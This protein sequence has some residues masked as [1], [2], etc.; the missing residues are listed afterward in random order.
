M[1]SN[2]FGSWAMDS[3]TDVS[4]L[5]LAG[6]DVRR[7]RVPSAAYVTSSGCIAQQRAPSLFSHC[8]PLACSARLLATTIVFGA[9]VPREASC[10]P[11]L[12]TELPVWTKGGAD[13]LFMS[14]A[15]W[16]G[17]WEAVRTRRASLRS[18]I[19]ISMRLMLGRTRRNKTF[20]FF[21][22][23][24]NGGKKCFR[25]LWIIMVEG[26]LEMLWI[27]P[28]QR[29]SPS[30]VWLC[31]LTQHCSVSSLM[32][33][34]LWGSRCQRKSNIKKL[35]R[36]WNRLYA[37]FLQRAHHSITGKPGIP[38]V[39]MQLLSCVEFAYSFW[40]GRFHTFSFLLL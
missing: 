36:G 30:N 21:W 28:T 29:V 27:D 20:L 35:N 16:N 18:K 7:L 26:M 11:V 14:S 34:S 9:A 25:W 1:F 37:D 24:N 3:A 22:E 13:H 23:V 17:A 4:L 39:W 40:T 32:P 6:P 10:L 15:A 5:G 12:W 19:V 8:L 2:S 31:Q 38:G 33:S